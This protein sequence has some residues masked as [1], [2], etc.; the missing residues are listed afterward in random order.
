MYKVEL[1]AEAFNLDSLKLNIENG[2]DGS[3]YR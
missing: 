2:C 1:L 3:L